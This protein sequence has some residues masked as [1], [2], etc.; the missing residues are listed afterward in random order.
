MQENEISV[1]AFCL[2][3]HIDGLQ[4]YLWLNNDGYNLDQLTRAA[5]VGYLNTHK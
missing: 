2:M 1:S 5:I 4:I 3:A